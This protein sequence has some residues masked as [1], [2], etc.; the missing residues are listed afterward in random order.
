MTVISVFAAALGL[1]ST[2]VNSQVAPV[3]V[4]VNHANVFILLPR[5]CC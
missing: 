3:G 5:L 4:S 1:L 2:V